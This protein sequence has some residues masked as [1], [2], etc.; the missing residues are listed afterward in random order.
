MSAVFKHGDRG[1][2]AIVLCLQLVFGL[3]STVAAQE[4]ATATA[5]PAK[6][7]QL[8]E[9]LDDPEVRQWLTAKQAAAP[10]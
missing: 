9:L 3:A 6:V 1:L 2:A 7:Q 5:P 10:A 4:P 8:I